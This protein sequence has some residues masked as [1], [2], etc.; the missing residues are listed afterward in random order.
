MSKASERGR[1]VRLEKGEA[2]VEF[3]FSNG[4][5]TIKNSLMQTGGMSAED[6]ERRIAMLRAKDWIDAS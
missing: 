1:V 5:A 2:F 4:A 6:A 3:I